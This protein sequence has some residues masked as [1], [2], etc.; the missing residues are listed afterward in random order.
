MIIVLNY[1]VGL[2]CLGSIAAC[3]WIWIGIV[4]ATYFGWVIT[5]CLFGLSCL[6]CVFRV[7]VLVV[8]LL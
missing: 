5:C 6:F 1:F 8:L 4:L 2:R 7:V 3:L